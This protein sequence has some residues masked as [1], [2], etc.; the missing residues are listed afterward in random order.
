MTDPG[1]IV[2]IEYTENFYGQQAPALMAYIA[3]LNGYSAPRVDREFTYCE[4]GCGQG[5]TSI[6]L[7]ALYPHAS[8]YASDFNS[9]HIQNA[10]ELAK[11]GKVDERH[12]V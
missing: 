3:A 12:A 9:A 10:R 11:A 8:F 7:A 4:L 2:D 6:G 1:Y 5:L